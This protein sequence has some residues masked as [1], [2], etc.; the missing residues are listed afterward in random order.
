MVTVRLMVVSRLMTWKWNVNGQGLLTIDL[1][2]WVLI[3]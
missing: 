1:S 3:A 2:D